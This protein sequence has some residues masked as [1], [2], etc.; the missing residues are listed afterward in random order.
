MSALASA[1]DGKQ[2][3]AAV[4]TLNSAATRIERTTV[5]GSEQ[6][7]GFAA[8]YD[9]ALNVAGRTLHRARDEAVK[10]IRETASGA[11]STAAEYVEAAT[12]RLN[13]ARQSA[14]RLV[15]VAERLQKPLGWAAAARM[16]LAL[17]PVAVALLMAV[18]TIWALVV[19][20]QWVLAQD[21]A[22]WLEITAGIGL[23]GLV[24]GAGFGL[25]RMTVWV[26]AALD[27]AAKLLG[28]NRR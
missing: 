18:Q 26:K 9:E 3:G 15:E 6:A 19:G 10:A 27:E 5:W 25:W 14:E 17:L 1:I 2:I 7:S 22:L 20:I 21:W 12:G 8:K 24:A 4:S 13:A 16:G 23:T 11:A 28:R